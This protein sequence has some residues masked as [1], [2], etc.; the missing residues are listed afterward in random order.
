MH[1]SPSTLTALILSILGSITVSAAGTSNDG[2]PEA[3]MYTDSNTN[4]TFLGY[5]NAGFHFGM[6]LPSD[7]KDD[8]IIQLVSPLKD[9]GGWGG[10]DFGEYMTGHLILAAWP[11]NAKDNTVMISPRIATGYEISN[12]ANLYKANPITITQIPDGT[13]VN[14]THVSATFVCG[15]CLNSDSFGASDKTAT[16]SY[17]Y[18]YD[19]VDDPSDVDTKLSD[20]TANGEPYGPFHVTVARAESSDFD[21]GGEWHCD[22]D[23]DCECW[24]VV[25]GDRCCGG[26]NWLEFKLWIVIVRK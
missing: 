21:H 16:F 17:A 11:Q 24:C 23:G 14:D 13:F 10:I 6:V 12:G 1:V 26:G 22:W 18:A 25:Y 4:M 3:S 19:P 15:G 2:I 20:H 8:L 7:P 5:A 9:G